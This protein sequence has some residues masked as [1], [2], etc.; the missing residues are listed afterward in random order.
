MINPDDFVIVR[1]RK[2]YKFAKFA[3]SPI[4]FEYD[5]W[6]KQAI[7]IIEVGA[8]TG[9]FS[10]ELAR[11][12][13]DKTIVAVDV[14]ADRLQRGAYVAEELGLTN[15]FFLRAR[16]DQLN[17][18]LKDQSAEAIWST[19]ADPFPKPGSAGRRMT[20]PTYLKIYKRILKPSGRFMIKHDSADFFFWSVEHLV[21][22]GWILS[23]ISFDLHDS[24]LHDDYKCMTS[25]ETKWLNEGKKTYFVQA[26]LGTAG[27]DTPG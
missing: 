8:G 16:A 6:Q 1:R 4:C 18:C 20:H 24:Q 7:D 12:Y 19:F 3:N 11:R 14:K 17:D 23:E 9:L 25:Y 22:T 10:V 26:S 21:R 27:N 2:K 5:Q 15:I 13:P